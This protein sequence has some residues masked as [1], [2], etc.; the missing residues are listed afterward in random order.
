MHGGTTKKEIWNAVV[1]ASDAAVA[2]ATFARKYGLR[3]A[4]QTVL[5]LDEAN[6]TEHIDLIKEILCD[7]TFDG[8]KLPNTTLK[9]VAA[10]NPYRR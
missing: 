5:F 7:G 10:C 1:A 9:Y 6:T 3:S 4:L 2:N 8:D